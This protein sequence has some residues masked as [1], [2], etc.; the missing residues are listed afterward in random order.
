M[1]VRPSELYGVTWPLAAFFLDRG[2]RAWANFVDRRVNEAEAVA[3]RQTRKMKGDPSG[4]IHSAKLV[5]FNKLMG[6]PTDL[7]Y[8][9]PTVPQKASAPKALSAEGKKI[10]LSRFSA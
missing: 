10:D 5:T 9:A 3:V 8:A 6:L 1:G 2:C 4:F 7:A